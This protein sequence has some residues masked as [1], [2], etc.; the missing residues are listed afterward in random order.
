MKS[1]MKVKVPVQYA[2]V[3]RAGS[4]PPPPAP[5]AELLGGG[6]GMAGFEQGRGDLWQA[7][8]KLKWRVFLASKFGGLS[9]RVNPAGCHGKFF[10]R[11]ILAGYFGTL[12]WRVFMANEA[13]GF[14]REG[15]QKKREKNV[16]SVDL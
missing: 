5:L 1:G 6:G 2:W 15:K 8:H 7:S 14:Q 3:G 10:W 16:Y 12:I 9:S 13:S 11:V 4:L